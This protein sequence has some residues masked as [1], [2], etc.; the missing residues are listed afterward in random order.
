M[1]GAD[2]EAL[3]RLSALIKHLRGD[4]SQRDYAGDLGISYG[5]VRAWEEGESFPSTKY[6]QILARASN[7]TL[8]ELMYYLQSGKPFDKTPTRKA[9]DLLPAVNELSYEEQLR[10]IQL[11]A[12]GL[13]SKPTNL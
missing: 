1:Y 12:G 7:Q 11:V 5:T 3:A 4:R 13:G 8:D 10:L 6:A 2:S 9:E